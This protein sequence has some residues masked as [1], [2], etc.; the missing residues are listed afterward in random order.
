MSVSMFSML[1][2]QSECSVCVC[3][4]VCVCNVCVCVCVR[5]RVYVSIYVILSDAPHCDMLL[6]QL[7]N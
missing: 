1:V 6:K 4:R 7:S 5:A 3:V 2:P